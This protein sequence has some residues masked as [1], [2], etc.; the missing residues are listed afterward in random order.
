MRAIFSTFPIVAA[1][2]HATARI[3]NSGNRLG[4]GHRLWHAQ[5]RMQQ[6]L[7]DPA[8]WV[9]TADALRNLS[10]EELAYIASWKAQDI[11]DFLKAAG[12]DIQLEPWPDNH[13]TF[14]MAGMIKLLCHFK[15]YGEHGYVVNNWKKAFRLSAGL[16]FFDY[17]VA[18]ETGVAIP[19]R[20]GDWVHIVRAP[21]VLSHFA[22]VRYALE[23]SQ[24]VTSTHRYSGVVLPQ[25]EFAMQV[26]VGSL[27]GLSATNPLGTTWRLCQALFEGRSSFGPDG[28]SFKAAFAAAAEK[29]LSATKKPHDGDLIVDYPLVASLWR[30]RVRMPLG[31]VM[32]EPSFFS[33]VD[34]KI[35][36]GGW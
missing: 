35:D 19:T 4:D 2:Q 22:L 32:I 9:P 31:V 15:E 3:L 30:P 18:N 7:L 5:N 11:N 24:N 20:E 10:D 14:G 27:L 36:D 17:G 12:F 26:D 21:S 34:V 8:I 1:L 28:I 29:G 6:E 33:D 25:W 13:R 23:T 16:R